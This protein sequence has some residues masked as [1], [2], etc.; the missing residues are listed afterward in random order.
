MTE[1][2]S[3]DEFKID[4]YISPVE[5]RQLVQKI[6]EG[7][8]GLF[9]VTGQA[10]TG[11]TT[12][13]FMIAYHA[14]QQGFP[15][16]VFTEDRDLFDL[17]HFSLPQSWVTH[18]VEASEQA[19]LDVTHQAIANPSMAI[20]IDLLNGNNDEAALIAAKAGHWV[21]T[22]IDTP[23]VGIDVLYNLRGWGLTSRD[24]LENVSG[25]VSQMLL[26]RL[27]GDCGQ[28]V[29]ASLEETRLVYPESHKTRE[30]WREVGCPICENRGTGGSWRYGR[31]A[32]FDV[33]LIDNEVRPRLADYLDRNILSYLPADK[34]FTM[35]DG[36]KD[37]VK[38]GRVGIQ[39]YQR[40][41]L[42]NP[43][44]RTQHFWEQESLRAKQF[45]EMFGRFVTQQLVER[46]MSQ[47]DFEQI[48]EGERRYVT[49]FFCDFR[50]FTTRS[51][52]S[53]PSEIF[54]M[55]NRYF[56]EIIDTVFQY[57]GT[58]D[59]FIG[60]SVMVVFGAPIEQTDRELRAVQCAIAIQ[61]KVA[62]INQL[63]G[64]EPI[65][66]GIGINSGEVIAGCLGS[67][68]RMDYTVLGDV[69]NTAARLES[70]AQPNQILIGA[71][72]YAAVKD[73]VE[74]RGIGALK[75]KGKSE[76]LEVF[77]VVYR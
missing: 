35:K 63:E 16:T 21:F 50:G 20:V 10:G 67:D 22:C 15:I 46:L 60:D 38:N 57:E 49:C 32:S 30:L 23:F 73:K 6:L 69:V 5:A 3:L 31:C 40:E 62:E 27:C 76:S 34:H 12:T 28:L 61:Q 26:P 68:R 4:P 71:E 41:V 54:Q 64:I 45:Q 70:Q 29:P 42:Q 72:T 9:P 13:L 53:S 66:I 39:T 48:V 14:W 24:M 36:S 51:E 56:R 33:L 52:Q 1:K 19:W 75:L 77:E 18:C 55:L 44:L 8:P 7:K 2:P 47:Q 43:L 74:C 11:K 25:V 65:H 37:L 59:K 58:I 17:L